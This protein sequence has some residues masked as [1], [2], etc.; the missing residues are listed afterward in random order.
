[1]ATP[2]PPRRIL[3]ADCDCFFV[4]VAQLEDPEGVGRL[5]RVIVGGRPEARGVVTSASY[6][7][8]ACGVRSA[9]PTA[10]ALRLCPDAAVVPVHREAC[11]RRS[12]EVR[13]ALQRWA[14]TVEAAS[15]DEFYLDLGGTERLYGE[16]ALERTAERI[17]DATLRE[18]GIR[19]S[20]G[21]GTQRTIAKLA[22]RLAKPNGVYVVPAGAEAEWMLRWRV[23]DLPSVGPAL[24]ATLERRGIGTVAEA[25]AL[26]RSTLE[27]WLGS[28]RGGWLWERVRGI[29]T[30]PV[31]ERKPARS[32][33]HERTFARDLRD[34]DRVRTELL[35]LATEV[36]A[37]LRARGVRARTLTVRVRDADLRDRQ[38]ART[39]ADGIESDRAIYAEASALLEALRADRW[40]GVRL[41]GVTASRLVPAEGREQPGLFD[42]AGE[43]ERDRSLSRAVDRL[44]ER[45]GDTA[46]L[47][48]RIVGGS[49]PPG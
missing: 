20:L 5:E 40:T 12:A 49:T 21:G 4:Q 48:G 38:R 17:R 18:T 31:R 2:P 27:R 45:F 24:A 3:L 1:M 36:G 10:H 15:I 43:N 29:D 25:R 13:R 41:L 28:A 42:A 7:A 8:R 33:G 37:G 32:F 11:G 30:A 26:D 35:R 14:P 34:E 19:I 6:A 16:E 39:L 23:A 22:T 9:M 47:P 46:L 44:R